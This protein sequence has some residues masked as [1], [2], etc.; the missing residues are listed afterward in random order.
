MLEPFEQ[1]RSRLEMLRQ[2]VDH[3]DED[4]HTTTLASLQSMLSKALPALNPSAQF[5]SV[6]ILDAVQSTYRSMYLITSDDQVCHLMIH[7]DFSSYSLNVIG[8]IDSHDS[9]VQNSLAAVLRQ[10]RKRPTCCANIL[11]KK[12]E[13]DG[14]ITS[15]AEANNTPEPSPKPHQVSGGYA[16]RMFETLKQAIWR[17]RN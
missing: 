2:M 13:S 11:S 16:R 17:P 6:N 15:L 12:L 3:L 8:P 5:E 4:F 10:A 14:D 9:D 7:G 1:D